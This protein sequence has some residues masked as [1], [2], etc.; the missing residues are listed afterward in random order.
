MREEGD[1]KRALQKAEGKIAAQ[2][3]QMIAQRNARTARN[4]T[5]NRR[6]QRGQRDGEKNIHGPNR[7]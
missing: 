7:G 4:D 5:G 6:Y 1:E 2:R 3:T